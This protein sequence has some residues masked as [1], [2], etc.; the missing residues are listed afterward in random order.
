MLQS[1]EQAPIDLSYVDLSPNEIYELLENKDLI[2]P[3]S[4]VDIAYQDYL[5]NAD[6]VAL[7]TETKKTA[8]KDFNS[9]Q[10]TKLW[11]KS[12]P[13][14]HSCRNLLKNPKD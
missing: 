11:L 2:N 9:A 13:Y 5:I 1:S 6:T 3:G 12:R 7:R 10:G 4:F 14:S 8:N